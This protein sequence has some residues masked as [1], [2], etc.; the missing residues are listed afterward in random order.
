[1]ERAKAMRR[2]IKESRRSRICVDAVDP[3]VSFCPQQLHQGSV[4]LSS[5]VCLARQY[6]A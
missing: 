1:M 4:R 3:A 5:S 2:F 6:V